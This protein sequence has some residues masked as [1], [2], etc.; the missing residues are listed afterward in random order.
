MRIV[1][2]ET[3][4]LRVVSRLHISMIQNPHEAQPEISRFP[5]PGVGLPRAGSV[6]S[7]KTKE[8]G[9]I[10]ANLECLNDLGGLA[11][12]PSESKLL[13]RC[14]C[15]LLGCGR[16]HIQKSLGISSVEWIQLHRLLAGVAQCD[17]HAAVLSQK[18]TLIW[19]RTFFLSASVRSGFWSTRSFTWSKEFLL[20][21]N[22]LR[23]DGRLRHA[24]FNQ[25]L[26]DASQHG[27]L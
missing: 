17:V 18:M 15:L 13:L 25:E 4:E 20:L 19:R 8:V 3:C 16:P 26:L 21:A 12:L 11:G 22:A 9:R 23:V 24:L 27:A 14:C 7:H 5:S 6:V 1:C 2:A 10:P